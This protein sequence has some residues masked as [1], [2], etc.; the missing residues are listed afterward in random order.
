MKKPKINPH[1]RAAILEVVDKQLHENN[2]PE[3]KRTLERLVKEGSSSEEAKDLIGSVVAAEI[4]EILKKK[5]EFN[6][7]RFVEALDKLPELPG[8][9]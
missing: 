3:T 5:E 9:E 7:K 2:P 8:E 4:F 6:H 1:L